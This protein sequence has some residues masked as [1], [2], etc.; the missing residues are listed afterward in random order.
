MVIASQPKITERD[1]A[2]AGPLKQIVVADILYADAIDTGDQLET[3]DY[4][5]LMDLGFMQKSVVVIVPLNFTYPR[6]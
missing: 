3:N 4:E 1:K 6:S 5:G 2:E